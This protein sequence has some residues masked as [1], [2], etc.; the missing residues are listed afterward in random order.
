MQG[1]IMHRGR[2]CGK[3]EVHGGADAG[4]YTATSPSVGSEASGRAAAAKRARDMDYSDR[5]RNKVSLDLAHFRYVKLMPSAHVD[6]FKGAVA[7][8]LDTACKAIVDDVVS[9]FAEVSPS[10]DSET[11]AAHTQSVVSGVESKL[12]VFNGLRTEHQEM[13]YLKKNVP[14]AKPVPR[15]M[16]VSTIYNSQSAAAPASMHTRRKKCIAYDFAADELL[17]R[18]IEHSSIARAQIYETVVSWSAAPS[19]S[20]Q[21]T[22]IVADITDGRVFLEHPVFGLR[23]RVTEQE[24]RDASESAP[25]R[26]AIMLYSDAFTPVNAL[27]GQ[28]HSHSI[29]AVM[30]CILNLRPSM[31]MCI[32]AIQLATLTRDVD[33]KSCGMVEVINGGTTSIG[34]QLRRFAAGVR[35]CLRKQ[36]GIGHADR[37]LQVYCVLATAD[38][39]A[40]AAMLPTK[41]STSAHQYDRH[42]DIDQQS[43]HYG[44]PNSFLSHRPGLPHHFQRRTMQGVR[45]VVSKAAQLKSATS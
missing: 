25:L 16:T 5:L 9:F 41:G 24:A 45:A 14:Y 40:M 20:P 22:Q 27:H 3:S 11:L 35:V 15:E 19:P 29:L 7:Q 23:A 4:A 39:P 6:I 18:L 10:F 21:S 30:Y 42:S 36:G 17:C 43:K 28:A 1:L 44:E 13:Q 34:A 26:I 32:P 2:F 37:D 8:W 38:F 31:R 33:A 12:D